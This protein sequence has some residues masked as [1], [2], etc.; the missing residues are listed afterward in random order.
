MLK[1]CYRIR[2]ILRS[3]CLP[4]TDGSNLLPL[5][6]VWE[7]TAKKNLNILLNAII[8]ATDSPNSFNF[9]YVITPLISDGFFY[10]E[11][12]EHHREQRSPKTT[13]EKRIFYKQD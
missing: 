4:T 7:I 10:V 1:D 9:H 6:C 11:D 3:Y 12:Q 5:L 2:S 13:T 8:I